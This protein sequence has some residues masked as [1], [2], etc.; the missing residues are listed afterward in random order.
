MKSGKDDYTVRFPFTTVHGVFVKR[1]KAATMR[2]GCILHLPTLVVVT[3]RG[4][5]MISA[6]TPKKGPLRTNSTVKEA[7]HTE[8]KA[9]IRT[10]RNHPYD[11][12]VL[13]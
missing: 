11:Q 7:G 3:H 13:P 2:Y 8:N 6:Y 10:R 12:Y 9:T 5:N 4:T 1:I